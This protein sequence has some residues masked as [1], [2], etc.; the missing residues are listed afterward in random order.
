MYMSGRNPMHESLREVTESIEQYL[1]YLKDEERVQTVTVDPALVA[2]LG[3]APVAPRA[4]APSPPQEKPAAAR[5][6]PAAPPV[7][8][9]KQATPPPS[10][11]PAPVSLEDRATAL[12]HLTERIAV[13]TACPLH[14]TRTRT[15]PGQGSTHPD[16]L[17]IG[18]GPGGEEDRQGIPF[19]GRSG[20][21]L[22]R[23]ITRMGYTR[24]EV[25]IGNIVKCR[26]TVDMA[27]QKDR[28][29]S[30]DE[31]AACLPYLKEQV[32]LL[33]PKVIVTLGNVALEGLFG[34]KGITRL[35]GEW[36]EFEGIPTMPTYHPSYLLRQGG[37]D[38]KA[39]WEVWEDMV[40]VLDRLGR[41][42]PPREKK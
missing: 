24:E 9:P 32:A 42:P 23:L 28:A 5:A 6:F 16:I 14:R 17:F 31:I 2:A 41:K 21:L 13:C 3:K 15:V 20:A 7:Q 27:M 25:F 37:E 33:Q 34:I 1:E 40:Q 22:T 10:V 18:E 39:F 38:K 19:V 26:P 30:A 8:A 11:V 35:R 12:G 36:L 29:P 4:P